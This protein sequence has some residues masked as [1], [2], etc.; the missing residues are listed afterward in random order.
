VLGRE[1]GGVLGERAQ[2][3]ADVLVEVT[4]VDVVG[5]RDPDELATLLPAWVEGSRLDGLAVRGP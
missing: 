1:L 2:V 4:R 3:L 5:Q